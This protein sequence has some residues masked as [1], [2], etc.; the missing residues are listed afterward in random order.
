[1]N[2]WIK[3]ACHLEKTFTFDSFESAMLFMQ[4]A[5]E[6]IAELDHHPTWTNTF[7]RIHII[8]ST[9]D[10]GNQVTEKD[11]A[12]ARVLDSLYLNFNHD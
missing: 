12:L 5:A 1:M 9:H 11:W 4:K 6:K 2:N 10:A 3:T 7:N 8:L